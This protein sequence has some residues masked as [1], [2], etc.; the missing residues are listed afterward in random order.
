MKKFSNI[1]FLAFGLHLLISFLFI[2]SPFSLGKTRFSR[3]Y[4]TYLLPGPFFSEARIVNSDIFSVSWKINEQWSVP[5]DPGSEYFKRYLENHNPTDLYES[6]L[7]RTL[8]ERLQM[9]ALAEDEILK[10]KPF[11]ALRKYLDDYY[12]PN[13]ADSIKISRIRQKA[14]D[15]VISMDT[16][17][18][19]SFK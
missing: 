17:N 11:L 18:V 16:L 5:I 9:H 1:L 8:Y 12:V 13:G 14:K 19:I 3:I 4:L 2:L 15:F 7:A 6:H 10:G